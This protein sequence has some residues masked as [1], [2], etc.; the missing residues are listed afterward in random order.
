MKRRILSLVLTLSVFLSMLPVGGAIA[1]TTD[2][3][4]A[5]ALSIF[6]AGDGTAS[7]PYE[8]P[9]LQA[10]LDFCDYINTDAKH[11]FGMYFKLTDDID[12]NG[13][14]N[15][16]W[17]PIGNTKYPF[18]GTF[19]GGEH[20]VSG[21]YINRNEDYQGLFGYITE[22]TVKNLT[23]KGTIFAGGNV[24][25]I[26][27]TI[28]PNSTNG[29][30]ENCKFEGDIGENGSGSNMAIGG[31][32]GRNHGAT[33]TGCHFTGT[34]TRKTMYVGGIAGQ[35]DGSNTVVEN[36]YN[37]GTISISG[38]AA[39]SAGGIAGII[40]SNVQIINCR[41]SGTVNGAGSTGAIGGITGTNNSG[42][43]EQCYNDGSID[44]VDSGTVGGIAGQNLGGTIDGCYNIGTITGKNQIAGI[45]GQNNTK[46]AISECY[47]AGAVTGT[48]QIGG[49]VGQ[50]YGNATVTNCYNEAAVTGTRYIG[51]IVAQNHTGTT[52]KSTTVGKVINCYNRGT[53]KGSSVG[54][55]VGVNGNNYGTGTVS[56]CYYLSSSAVGGIGGSDK[57]AQAES[58]TEECFNSGEVS[59]KLQNPE[60]VSSTYS[61]QSKLVWVQEIVKTPKDPYPL[62]LNTDIG[63]GHPKVQ[64][65]TFTT[66]KNSEY[67]V[68]YTNSG[69][70]VPIPPT[71]P[72]DFGFLFFGWRKETITGEVFTG[73]VKENND[74][75]IVAIQRET[76]G[77]EDPNTT[78]ITTTYGNSVQKDLGEWV[79]YISGTTSSHGK[80]TYTITNNGGISSATL[81]DE[82]I[83]TIPAGINAGVYTLTISAHEKDPEVSLLS[84]GSYGTSDVTLTVKVIVEKAD[85]T[86]DMFTYKPPDDLSCNGE[87][88][89]A[90][91]TLNNG[92]IGVGDTIQ[93]KYYKDGSNEPLESPPTEEGKYIVKIDV[94]E[95]INYK[96]AVD[97][98]DIGWEF[99]IVNSAGGLTISTIVTG[100]AGDKDKEFTFTVVL[101]DDTING[102]FGDMEFTNGVATFT[103]KHG[104]SISA[105]DLSD[106]ITYTITESDND[107]YAV[108]IEGSSIDNN[109]ASQSGNGQCVGRIISNSTA[110]LNFVNNRN[111]SVP[112]DATTEYDWLIP[113][114][115]MI[116][117]GAIFLTLKRLK[118]SRQRR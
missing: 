83:L 27:G 4:E 31:I 86:A 18:A 62:L 14:E 52:S 48:D 107:G 24:G 112:T 76:F 115:M 54:G 89:V 73:P 69:G 50:N 20:K 93:I 40:T 30:I 102:K 110:Q 92:Y 44:G 26:A 56:N 53:I 95:G 108:K 105:S 47:N 57:A 35:N 97:L 67:A 113:L 34:V 37:E 17:T 114:F 9:N 15:N 117:T 55:I 39:G 116:G 60:K 74:L 25:G 7:A 51:G 41:N 63:A 36:C 66:T 68:E 87:P 65:I 100:N 10:M 85:L 103:L 19:D 58:K 16:Q 33:V 43:L 22:G 64:R 82:S 90:T 13:N 106:S 46:G 5:A 94:N 6:A 118:T 8:I 79:S 104:E 11:G 45:A 38:G 2:D 42:K 81:V 71:P 59:W 3:N 101:S 49:I 12:L 23:V 99:E 98:T 61:P 84:I 70:T 91:V 78:V 109:E 77:A 80:F 21:L 72:P 88:K 96:S 29:R 111:L 1:A 28:Y 32:V 75:T